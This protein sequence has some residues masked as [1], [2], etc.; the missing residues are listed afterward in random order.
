VVRPE[1][2][3]DFLPKLEAVLGKY[4][5]IYTVAGHIGDGNFHIIPLRDL[6]NDASVAII[7]SLSKEVYDL[8]RQF[9]GSITGE[10][11]DGLVRTPFLYEMYSE[12]ILDYFKKTK[13]IFDKD[14]I[15]N[16]RKKVGGDIAYS[17]EHIDRTHV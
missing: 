4:D 7:E 17:F 2:L 15:F 3:P 5:L 9:K 10:H 6:H 12:S 14:Y 1:F 16:P 11:N 13:E 8:I